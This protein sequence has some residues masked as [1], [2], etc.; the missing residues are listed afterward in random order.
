MA[1]GVRRR[2][3]TCEPCAGT[4]AWKC[5]QAFVPTPSGLTASS[6]RTICRWNASFV[7]GLLERAPGPQGAQSSRVAGGKATD[8]VRVNGSVLHLGAGELKA[9]TQELAG[10]VERAVGEGK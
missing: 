8:P 5:R 6:P 10:V 1:L 2:C 9:F 7:K 4:G 3:Q